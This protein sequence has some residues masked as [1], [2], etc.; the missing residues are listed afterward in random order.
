MISKFLTY[1]S[2]IQAAASRISKFSLFTSALVLVYLLNYLCCHVDIL[3]QALAHVFL[4]YEWLETASTELSM[5]MA[6]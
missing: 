4:V 1:K 5:G 2:G 6:L 3:G